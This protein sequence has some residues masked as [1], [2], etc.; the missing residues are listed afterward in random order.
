[1][2]KPH[3]RQY[4]IRNIPEYVDRVLRQRARSSQKSFNQ[5]ALEALIAGADE[6][7]PR[8]DLSGIAG[9]L[10]EDE[11]AA[12]EEEIRRQHQVAL[13]LWK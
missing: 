9:S 6:S 12:L 10:M 13:D 1:M 11:A 8:R 5:I 2:R 3:G 7:V 4:T